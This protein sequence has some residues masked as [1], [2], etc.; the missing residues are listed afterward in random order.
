MRGL[1]GLNKDHLQGDTAFY[2]NVGGQDCD[3][4]TPEAQC[5]NELAKA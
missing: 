3:K 4:E 5:C 1:S 2:D